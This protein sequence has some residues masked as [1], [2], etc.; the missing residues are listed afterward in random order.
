MGQKDCTTRKAKGFVLSAGPVLD[1]VRQAQLLEPF[2]VK[3]VKEVMFKINRFKSP[4]PNDYESGFYE[5]A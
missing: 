5:V 2:I 4:G 3:E 1:I